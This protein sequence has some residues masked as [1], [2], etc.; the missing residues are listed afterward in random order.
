MDAVFRTNSLN[1]DLREC[2]VAANAFPRESLGQLTCENRM[3]LFLSAA[4][5]VVCPE[6]VLVK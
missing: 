3:D 4:F 2:F 6:P 5:P 1:V